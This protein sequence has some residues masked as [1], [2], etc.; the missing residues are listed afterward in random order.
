MPDAAAVAR[1]QA[2]RVCAAS[3]CPTGTMP[4]VWLCS[5]GK[6]YR[7]SQDESLRLRPSV[8]PVAIR[9][10]LACNGTNAGAIGE[11]LP[12]MFSATVGPT[13]KCVAQSRVSHVR[14]TLAVLPAMP[15]FRRAGRRFRR[16]PPVARL[17]ARFMSARA[18]LRGIVC[19]IGRC[20][21]PCGERITRARD[22]R[23]RGTAAVATPDQPGASISGLFHQPDS[24]ISRPPPRAGTG[25][26]GA[27]LRWRG[28][29]LHRLRRHRRMAGRSAAR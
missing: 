24:S 20:S 7:A 1:Y 6:S 16:M 29:M 3:K 19:A 2:R 17:R 11:T 18:C 23:A 27:A 21:D 12:E 14:F 5:V 25:L 4:K 8:I 22:H 10:S 9:P 26:S 15:Q 28:R 13:R